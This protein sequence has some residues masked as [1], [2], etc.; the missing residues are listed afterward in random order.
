MP[1]I[2]RT[3]LPEAVRLPHL[4]AYRDRIKNQLVFT[5]GAEERK[6]LMRMMDRADDNK[7]FYK[8]D[9]DPLPGAIE[10]F[11]PLIFRNS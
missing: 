4:T 11:P 2:K 7:P 5:V 10:E 6:H 9:S 8:S 3:D 1:I